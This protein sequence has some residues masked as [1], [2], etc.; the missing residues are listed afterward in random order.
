M[1]FAWFDAAKRFRTNRKPPILHLQDWRFLY[2]YVG[3]RRVALLEGKALSSY[4]ARRVPT[5]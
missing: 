4:A 1:R 2:F 3:T 5:F